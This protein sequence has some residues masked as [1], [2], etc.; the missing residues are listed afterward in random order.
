MELTKTP[1]NGLY[2]FKPSVFKDERGYFIESYNEKT[3]QELGI[4]E[5][6]VQDNQSCSQK[7]VVRGLH[8]QKPPFAQAKLVRIIQGSAI[9]FAV[10]IRKDSPTYGQYFSILLSADNFLQFFIPAGFAHGFAALED[11]TLFA[12]KCSNFYH[13]ASEGSIKYNDPILNIDWQVENPLISEKD[14]CG[15]DFKHFISPFD[16]NDYKK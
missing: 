15:E 10:D 5:H 6:F 16:Y 11:H 9:D 13:K 3:F 14:T 1:I 4:R 7:G 8:F 12:Y 2:V